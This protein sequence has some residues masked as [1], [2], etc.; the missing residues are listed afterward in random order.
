MFSSTPEHEAGSGSR[1]RW[2]KRAPQRMLPGSLPPLKKNRTT[3]CAC[4]S[5]LN[6]AETY[7]TALL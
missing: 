1:L 6:S 5:S 3:N 2:L 7:L 4:K